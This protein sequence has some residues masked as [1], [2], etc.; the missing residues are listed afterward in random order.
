[1]LR[2]CIIDFTGNWYKH[3]PL[4]EFFNKNSFHTS[5]FMAP[6]EAFY[7]RRCRSPIGWLKVGEFSLLGPN[8]I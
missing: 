5:I 6:Y 8:L 2:A 1:M 3:L 4:V 7:G